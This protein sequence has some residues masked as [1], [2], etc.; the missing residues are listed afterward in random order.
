MIFGLLSALSCITLEAL[1]CSLLTSTTTSLAKCVRWIASSIAAS[2]PPTTKILLFLKIGSPPSQIAQAEIPFCQNS[3]SPAICILF[4]VAP[5][6][7][8][9][10]SAVN[11]SD[12]TLTSNGLLLK[13]TLS[14]VLVWI[15]APELSDCFLIWLINWLPS[16]PSGKPGKFSTT[17]VVVSWPPA[18]IP[19]AIN[20][21]NING[22]S[23]AFPV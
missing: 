11:T 21:S 14:T 10:L 22:S 23:N 8:I 5:V 15:S 20:P 7:I 9:K 17:V 4:A 12:Q 19:P 13:S 16:I 2:P 6:A 1:S 18:A 3:S